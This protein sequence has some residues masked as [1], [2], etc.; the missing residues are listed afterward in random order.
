MIIRLH[1]HKRHDEIVM[2]STPHEL[3][4]MMGRFE[5]ARFDSESKCYLLEAEHVEAFT[6]FAQIHGGHQVLDERPRRTG[7][8]QSGPLPECSNCGRPVSRKTSLVLGQCPACGAPWTPMIF[9]EVREDRSREEQAA[10]NERGRAK[11]AAALRDAAPELDPAAVEAATGRH[12]GWCAANP[13]EVCHNDYGV[14]I[15]G[16]HSVRVREL[17][18]TDLW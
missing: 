12:C 3:A 14:A 9:R 13:G 18:T 4:S 8:E 16:V 10:I 6:R 2:L 17:S 5:A 7:I 15:R 1:K 11:V